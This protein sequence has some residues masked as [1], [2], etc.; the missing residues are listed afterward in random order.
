MQGYCFSNEKHSLPQSTA[1]P[2]RR[3]SI[4]LQLQYT[5]REGE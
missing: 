1:L 5:A 3:V 4:L 2:M